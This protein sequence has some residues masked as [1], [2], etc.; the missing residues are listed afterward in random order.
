MHRLRSGGNFLLCLAIN[1][2]LNADGLIP[3]VLLLILHFWL[4]W[5]LWLTFAAAGAWLLI[6]IVRMAILRW[7]NCCG[8]VP[9]PPRKNKNPYSAGRYSPSGG[10]PPEN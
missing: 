4:G 8:N 3:A 6:L 7:A 2:A 9:D 1:M 5:P 10:R